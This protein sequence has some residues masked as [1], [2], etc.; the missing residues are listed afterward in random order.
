MYLISLIKV[1]INYYYYYYYYYY[2]HCYHKLFYYHSYN[3]LQ[4]GSRHQRIYLV[5]NVYKTLCNSS[6]SCPLDFIQPLKEQL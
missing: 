5:K 3:L 1:I 6:C 4:K 2:H